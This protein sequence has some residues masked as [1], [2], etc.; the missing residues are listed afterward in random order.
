MRIVGQH[1]ARL[2]VFGHGIGPALQ[3]DGIGTERLHCGQDQVVTDQ[4]HIIVMKACGDRQIEHL[5]HPPVGQ[6]PGAGPAVFLVDRQHQHIR[7]GRKSRFDPI[8]MMRVDVDIGHTPDTVVAQ[9]HDRQS[10]IV[11]KAEPIGPVWHAVMGAAAGGKDYSC[12]G[13]QLA[14]QNHRPGPR[15]G[16][17]KHLREYRIGGR[18]K[19]VA[20]AGFGTDR[21]IRLGR[22][23]G[24]DIDGGM[25]RSQSGGFGAGAGDIP[26]GRQPAQSAGQVHHGGHPGHPQGMPRAIGRAAINL[27]PDKDW[28]D[29]LGVSRQGPPRPPL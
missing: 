11:Q 27:R 14:R 10:R 16:A 3:H 9:G 22:H 12:L 29:R 4:R 23:K 5:P 20:G 15:G 24:R 21:L 18:A 19:V 25:K 28:L 26:F 7:I 13:Q 6:S 1:Q 8:G 17:T 2:R